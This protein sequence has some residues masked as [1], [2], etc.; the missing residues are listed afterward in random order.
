M[1][2][3]ERRNFLRSTKNT[4]EMFYRKFTLEKEKKGVKT[5]SFTHFAKQNL[6]FPCAIVILLP[7]SNSI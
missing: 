3:N 6:K 7:S 2:Q 4:R 5:Q 1:Q